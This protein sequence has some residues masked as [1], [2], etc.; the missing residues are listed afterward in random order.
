MGSALCRA[1]VEKGHT[2]RAFHRPTSLLKLLEE[3]PVEHVSGSLNKTE[4]VNRAVEGMDAVFHCAAYFSLRED[5]GAMYS[6]VVEGTR[7]LLQAAR[8]A[9]VK[10]LV[11]TSSAA[12]LGVPEE[13][14]GRASQVR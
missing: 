4:D 1:L 5:P 9:G 7:S 3:L 2:V 11:Y 13:A 8:R 10:R 6:L 14:S 12:A